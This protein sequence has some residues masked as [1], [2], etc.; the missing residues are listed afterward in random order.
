MVNISNFFVPLAKKSDFNMSVRHIQS[1]I[2]ILDKCNPTENLADTINNMIREKTVKPEQVR[3]ILSVSLLDKWN[4]KVVSENIKYVLE[5]ASKFTQEI[6]KWNGIDIVLGYDHP[7]LGFLAINP[8]NPGAASIIQGFRK[9]ELLLIY[10]GKQDKGE[11]SD[12]LAKTIVFGILKLFEN[13]QAAV[14]AEA[15]TGPFKYVEPKKAA[16]VKE[17]KVA[18]KK[19]VKRA[20][21]GKGTAPVVKTPASVQQSS[22]VPSHLERPSAVSTGPKKMSQLVSVPVSNELFHN[23]NV[24]AWKRI[25]RSYNAK[26]PDAEVMIFYDGE[27]IVD[28]NTLFKWGKVKHGSSIQFAIS[29]E[30]INDLSKLSKYF[31][32][33][34]SPMFEAFLH[35]SPDTVLNLF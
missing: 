12:S 31:R 7:D 14:P 23:G 9:N 11:V 10:V 32:Q 22:S 24:E 16:P 5:D 21:A 15:K 25:I 8:K 18:A 33:G 26:Y 29:A 34:A 30:E 17:R 28:I 27:R 6:G 3:S 2:E 13:K 1:V 35:G 20:P 4:Y 19:T